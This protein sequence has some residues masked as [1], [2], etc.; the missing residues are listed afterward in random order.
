MISKGEK[1]HRIL[2]TH[3]AHLS[4]QQ[5]L[6]L[7][8]GLQRRA[9]ISLADVEHTL[10]PSGILLPSSIFCEELTPFESICLYLKDYHHFTYHS[11]ASLIN[12]DDRTI[13]T[14]YQHAAKK[15]KKKFILKKD[16]VMIPVKILQ[17][18]RLSVLEQIVTY[19][20][21][22]YGFTYHQIAV[23]IKRDDRT[24]WTVYQRG[25]QKVKR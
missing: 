23:L 14:V 17:D 22:Y 9:K 12:R 15:Q 8:E 20:K 6:N 4:K 25:L 21:E 16:G 11:I 5:L 10:T 18:R 1:T 19:L 2:H 24:I 3:L 7:V 13:W